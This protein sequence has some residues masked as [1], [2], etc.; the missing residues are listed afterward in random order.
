M[1]VHYE[2][3]STLTFA[4]QQTTYLAEAYDGKQKVRCN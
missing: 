2:G 3:N 1:A 4:L